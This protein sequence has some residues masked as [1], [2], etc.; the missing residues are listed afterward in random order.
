MPSRPG[1]VPWGLQ[2]G[3]AI[4]PVENTGD[5]VTLGEQDEYHIQAIMDAAAEMGASFALP[6]IAAA[7]DESTVSL[8]EQMQNI[9]MEVDEGNDDTMLPSLESQMAVLSSEQ[10]YL[11]AS[12]N[13]RVLL[14]ICVGLDIGDWNSEP[15]ASATGKQVFKPTCTDLQKEALCQSEVLQFTHKP[16]ASGWGIQTCAA[17]LN[18]NPITDP[19]DVTFIKARE[20]AF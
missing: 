11:S 6:N 16:H 14:S 5:T 17:Y 12:N 15:Y 13:K 4:P 19:G 1:A 18:Q 2:D 3:G 20:Q 10:Y 8:T 9:S 7:S